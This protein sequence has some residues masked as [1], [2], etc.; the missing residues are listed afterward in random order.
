MG[1]FVEKQN[2]LIHQYPDYNEGEQLINFT[3]KDIIIT[4][5][6]FLISVL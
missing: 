6:K 3:I 5:L 4:P 2:F 1:N